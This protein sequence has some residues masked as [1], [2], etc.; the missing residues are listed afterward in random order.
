MI[1]SVVVD[2][3][4]DAVRSATLCDQSMRP[5][6]TASVAMVRVAQTPGSSF[7]TSASHPNPASALASAV[8]F[9]A[10]Q[11]A[12]AET[13]CASSA[14]SCRRHAREPRQHRT[15]ALASGAR[16]PCCRQRCSRRLPTA[17]RSSCGRGRDPRHARPHRGGRASRCSEKSTRTL[18][19]WSPELDHEVVEQPSVDE[20][21]AHYWR[22]CAVRPRNLARV[23][24]LR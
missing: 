2:G 1:A 19:P 24:E 14:S 23:F 12:T 16:R 20:R 18:S 22:D 6:V 4:S 13:M 21:R 7:S 9:A 15:A 11:K 8:E 10:S 17:S 5:P 3:A